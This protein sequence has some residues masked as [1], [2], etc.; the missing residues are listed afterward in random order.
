VP[1]LPTCAEGVNDQEVLYAQNPKKNAVLVSIHSMNGATN[2]MRTGTQRAW[3]KK[4]IL[5]VPVKGLPNLGPMIETR[6]LTE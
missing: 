3:E 5:D 2:P 6:P 4:K 1:S